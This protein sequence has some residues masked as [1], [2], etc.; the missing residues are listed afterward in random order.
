LL[1]YWHYANQTGQPYDPYTSH[2][3]TY[4]SLLACGQSQGIDIRPVSAGGSIRPGDILFIRSGFN[5]AYRTKSLE[6]RRTLAGREG[7][8]LCYTGLAQS[9]EMLDWLHDSYISAVAGDAPS[10]E[11]WPTKEKWH[12]HEYLLALWGVPIG[13]MVDL[14]RLSERCREVGR[15]T[16]FFTSCPANVEGGVGTHINGLA[17][18]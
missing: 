2:S 12:L 3:I 13:E 4:S 14:E 18:F 7:R 15:W 6:E 5:A 17:F 16:F 9:D 1:D 10:L 11:V 8:K